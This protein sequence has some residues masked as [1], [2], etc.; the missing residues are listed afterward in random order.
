M[1]VCVRWCWCAFLASTLEYN[2]TTSSCDTLGSLSKAAA[3]E[4]EKRVRG[5]GGGRGFQLSSTCCAIY[6]YFFAYANWIVFTCT[7]SSTVGKGED[8][9]DTLTSSLSLSLVLR[10]PSSSS[11]GLSP[12]LSLSPIAA[13][14]ARNRTMASLLR[15]CVLSRISHNILG[16]AQKRSPFLHVRTT[17]RGTH[18]H[19]HTEMLPLRTQGINITHCAGGGG[20]MERERERISCARWRCYVRGT[21]PEYTNSFAISSLYRMYSHVLSSSSPGKMPAHCCCIEYTL[22]KR[23][24]LLG[25][26]LTVF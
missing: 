25:A 11:T 3:L 5:G 15:A 6:V 10:Q 22:P 12:S 18:T 4:G 24:L 16:A 26:Q 2:S 23:A 13:A 19:T 9:Q 7:L 21:F 20:E 8:M 14:C 1:N 17:R